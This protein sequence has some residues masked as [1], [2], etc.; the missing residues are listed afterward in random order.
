MFPALSAGQL[1]RWRYAS[2]TEAVRE[3]LTRW[4][5]SVTSWWRTPAHNAT[6]AGS[7]A[8]SAHLTGTAVDLVF[9]PGTEPEPGTFTAWCTANGCKAERVD[10]AHAA[11]PGPGQRPEGQHWHLEFIA[12]L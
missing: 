11:P 7:V 8:N 5:A 4:P 9:D 2:F 3:L 12:T 10:A 6:L 1:S